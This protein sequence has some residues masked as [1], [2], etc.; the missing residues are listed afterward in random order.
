MNA[1]KQALE[2][3][4]SGELGINLCIKAAKKA[5]EQRPEEMPPELYDGM[6]VYV[7]LGVEK[8]E[9]IRPEMVSDV[10]DALVRLIRKRVRHSSPQKAP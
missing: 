6:A 5:L 7:A 10:L 8:T 1:W 9:K 4:A 3:I 2:D